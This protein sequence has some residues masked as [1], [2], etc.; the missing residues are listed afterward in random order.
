[1]SLKTEATIEDLYRVPENGKAELIDGALVI[2][3]ATGFLP[4]LAG[5]QIFASLLD[6]GNRTRSG[7]G[8]PDNVGFMVNLPERQDVTLYWDTGKGWEAFQ[9]NLP[10]RRSFSPDA[11]FF[12]GHPPASPGK[13]LEEAPV[14]AVE[15]RSENDYGEMA[16]KA[17]ACKRVDYFDAGTLVVW[18]VD[19]LQGEWVKVYRSSD[20]WNPAVYR[21]GDLAEAEPAVPGWQLAVDALFPNLWH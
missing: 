11:A 9:T 16:E 4:G 13:F 19:V 14:F 1:M 8:I 12:T 5:G 7:Y 17:I 6:Y 2:M 10:K 21:R 20:A 3:G 15:V 18:D